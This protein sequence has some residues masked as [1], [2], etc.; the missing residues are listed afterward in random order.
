M[1]MIKKSLLIAF[2]ACCFAQQANANTIEIT[3]YSISSSGGLHE[4]TV[5]FDDLNKGG[6]VRCVI[7]KSDGKA[8]G[9]GE[10][11]VYGVDTILIETSNNIKETAPSCSILEM[12]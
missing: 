3:N 11:R 10:K 1:N 7:R 12:F 6:W 4:V 5:A 9:M 8:V 2:T